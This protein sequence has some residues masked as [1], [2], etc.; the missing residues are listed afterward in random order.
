[1]ALDLSSLEEKSSSV[2]PTVT[3]LMTGKPLEILLTDI[4]EDPEQPRKEF[5][6]EAMQGMTASIKARGVK[7]PISV[8]THPS[9]PGMWM[10]NYG[11]RRYRGSQAAGLKTIPAFVDE[12][13]DTYDQVIENIQRDD[14]KPMELALF[15]KRR[16]DAG[17][18]KK[19]VAK[20][21]GK[22][23]AT[24]TQHL[25]LID[26]P[27]CVE[28]AYSSGKCNSPKTLYELRTLHEKYPAE[29]DLWCG[30]SVEITRRAVASLA[31]DLKG[32]KHYPSMAGI[33]E[34]PDVKN[35]GSDAYGNS[36]N[37]RVSDESREEHDSGSKT[38]GVGMEG[39]SAKAKKTKVKGE[40]PD[41]DA[42]IGKDL[43]ELSSWPK[44]RAVSDPN[45][46]TKPLMLVEFD[47]RSAAVLLS[48]RP[49]MAGLIHIR[50]EDGGGDQEVEAGACKI[51]LLTEG[52]I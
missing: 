51:H 15:I 40:K 14:L 23:G 12:A 6:E 49:S 2:A 17:D 22:D 47:G 5:S 31:S 19:T 33:D 18:S 1:M 20:N 44:G 45:R 29:V 42:S 4:E 3:V 13:Q 9:R 27:A 36:G 24:I 21:L 52:G 28:E 50:Y 34:S 26:P 32:S 30:A 25:S 48:H 46:M 38:V 39:G 8:R 43:G 41:E 37:D 11:A 7:T 35:A 16:L 10:L